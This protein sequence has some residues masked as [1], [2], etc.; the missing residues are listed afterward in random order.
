MDCPPT[1]PACV[2]TWT[3]VLF[4]GLAPDGAWPDLTLRWVAGTGLPLP[5]TACDVEHGSLWAVVT[6]HQ[7][8]PWSWDWTLLLD[9]LY[10]AADGSTPYTAAVALPVHLRDWSYDPPDN[11]PGHP[12][13]YRC[14]GVNVDG[15]AIGLACPGEPAPQVAIC[16]AWI[17]PQWSW[18]ED[19]DG[20]GLIDAGD[21][22]EVLEQWG[23]PWDVRDF[24]DVLLLWG[25]GSPWT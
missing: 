14:S 5:D 21:L 18:P 6:D 22:L 25:S 2:E 12:I 20:S 3:S 4:I 24:L 11:L 9:D 15:A 8:D 19:L 10:V 17:A 23:A 1:P 7:G 16:V 13:T